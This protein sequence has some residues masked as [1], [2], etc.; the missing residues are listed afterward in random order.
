MAQKAPS[1]TKPGRLPKGRC[2]SGDAR[3]PRSLSL[4]FNLRVRVVP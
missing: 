1:R 4:P 2:V 3:E